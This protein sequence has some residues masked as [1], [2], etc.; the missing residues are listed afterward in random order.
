MNSASRDFNKLDEQFSD[1]GKCNELLVVSHVKA[2]GGSS[3]G[4][5]HGNNKV[6]NVASVDVHEAKATS[7]DSWNGPLACCI[8][9]MALRRP[10]ILS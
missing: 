2:G 3:D 7:W 6:W 10:F 4:A 8:H 5:A 1:I 9:T